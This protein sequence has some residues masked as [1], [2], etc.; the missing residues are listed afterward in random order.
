MIDY[1]KIV[2]DYR[3]RLAELVKN[4]PERKQKTIFSCDV[5]EEALFLLN[6]FAFQ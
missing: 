2:D 4:I 5:A 3:S 6:I 1:G